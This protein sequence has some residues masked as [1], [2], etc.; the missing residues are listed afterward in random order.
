MP[1]SCHNIF[2]SELFAGTNLLHDGLRKDCDVAGGRERWPL[3]G[4]SWCISC[5]CL[6][7][8][9][10]LSC[11]TNWTTEERRSYGVKPR[12]N[13]VKWKTPAIGQPF[14]SLS[15]LLQYFVRKELH[16]EIKN[17]YVWH[18]YIVWLWSR[19][20]EKLAWY[21][22]LAFSAFISCIIGRPCNPKVLRVLFN[23]YFW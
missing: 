3:P 14:W 12:T 20:L 9:W 6:S 10:S 22:Y 8:G 16:L 7:S 18:L 13:T 5:F 2:R 1:L 23:K 17:C 4:P 11:P 19:Y 21:T 15:T